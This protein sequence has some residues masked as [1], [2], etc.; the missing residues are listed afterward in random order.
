MQG[1]WLSPGA[2]DRAHSEEASVSSFGHMGRA[3]P[4]LG[5]AFHRLEKRTGVPVITVGVFNL[6]FC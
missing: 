4:G 2:E 3:V 5:A 6:F 1:S